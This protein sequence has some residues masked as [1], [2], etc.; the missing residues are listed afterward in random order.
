MTALGLPTGATYTDNLNGTATFNWTPTFSQS[1]VYNVTFIASDGTLADSEV[2]AITVNNVNQPPVLATIGP[3]TA[4]EGALLAFATSATDP[5]GAIPSLTAVGLPTGAAYVDSLNGRGRFTWTPGFTQAGVYNVTFIASDGTLAD[6]EVVAI[7]VVGVNMPPV[8]ATI[9][10]KSV[11]AGANLNFNTSATD[12]NATIPA[13]TAVNLP[14]GATYTNN[15]NGTGTFNWTPTFAQ[16]GLYNVTFIASDGALADSEVVAIT[17]VFVNQPPVLAAIGAKSV[18]EAVNLNFVASASDPNGTN[19]AMTAVGLPTGATYTD[20]ANGTATFNWTPTLSQAGLYN[21]TFIASD[22]TLADS[23]VVVITVTDVN[24]PPVLTAIGPKTT[25]EGTVLSFATSATDPD[26]TIPA[27]TAVGLPTGAAYVDSL[28]G[29]GRFTWTPNYT[30]AGVYNVTFIA[31]D[32][33]LADSEIVAITVTDAGN[34]PPVLAAIGPHSGFEGAVMT[35]NTSATDPD[36]TIP[37]LTA[38]NLPLNATYFDSANG[39]GTFTFTP[40]YAQAGVYNVTFIASDGTLADSELVVITISNADRAPILAAIGPQSVNAGSNLTFNVTATDPDSTIPVLT[41]INLPLHASFGDHGNGTGIF[42][43]VPDMLQ[44]GIYN[45]TFIASDGILADSEVVPITVIN[46]SN[47]PPVLDSIGPKSVYEGGQL[48]FRIH[49]TDDGGIPSL[50]VSAVTMKNFYTF[51]DSGNGSGSFT[52]V[53]DY[54]SAGIDT[55][56]FYAT[57]AQGASSFE[58]VQITTFDVNQPPTIVHIQDYTVL[59]GDSLNIRVVATDSTDPNGPHLSLIAPVKPTGSVFTDSTGGRASLRWKPTVADTG[60]HTFIVLCFDNGIP[61]MSDADTAVITVLRTNQPPVLAYIGPKS[62]N[63]GDTLRIH[64]SATDPDGTIPFFQ[65]QNMP[66]NS[67]MVDSANGHALFTFTPTFSQSGLYSVKFI[68]SDGNKTDYE[69][70]MI[71]V[72][73]IP[74]PPVLT[75]PADTQIVREG[76]SVYF[77]ISVTDPDGTI[78]TLK[79]DSTTI[80]VHAIF[81]DSLNGGGLFRFKPDFTQ[82][83]NYNVRF[84]ATD[85]VKRDTGIVAIK[86]IEAG[87]QIPVMT[88]TPT[89]V[90]VKEQQKMTIKVRATD[91]DGTKPVLTTSTLP[92]NAAFIDSGTGGGAFTWTTQQQQMGTYSVTFYATDSDTSG[93]VDSF[94]VPIVVNDSI[95]LPPD[96]GYDPY[97]ICLTPGSGT[98]QQTILEGGQ[99]QFRIMATL[100]DPDG[101]HPYFRCNRFTVT[102][103]DTTLSAMPANMTL[104]D[105]RNDTANFNFQPSFSQNGQYKLLFFMKDDRDTTR[106]RNYVLTVNV[107]NQFAP[108]V[109]DP[110]G[111]LS[112]LEGGT[113]DVMVAGSDPDGGGVTL[114]ATGLPPGATFTTQAGQPAG[115]AKS[116][117]LYAPNFAA[118]GVYTTTFKVTEN[119]AQ[120]QVD[121]EVVTIT[122]INAANQKPVIVKLDSL[123]TVNVT[124]EVMQLWL[125]SSDPD[126]TTPTLSVS[127]TPYVPY[128]AVFVDSANGRGSFRFDPTDLQADSSYQLRFV[129]SDGQLADTTRIRIQ[130]VKAVRGDANNDATIDISDVVYLIGY[131]FASNPAPATLRNGDANGD[132]TIDISDC[133]YLINYIF[134]NGPVPPP[135]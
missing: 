3:K 42:V 17:V 14:T 89:S 105:N 52:Y 43:F 30:Q 126:G 61:S 110:I 54:Y 99:L 74:Q 37:A 97:T 123:K 7:T 101:T 104:V 119:T 38:I 60:A 95:L 12:P 15:L 57:D 129:A 2:V 122:V 79:V 128:N 40:T 32:G 5:D 124:N 66:V 39:R 102:G 125:R 53:P 19:P 25:A 131:I 111:A 80:P 116:R 62:V 109:L 113:L 8:L 21:V 85:G 1:G 13:M 72:V 58:R 83:G 46:T 92:F 87:N 96:I 78:D 4:N 56:T 82:S 77:R 16:A 20:H 11:N 64:L 35:F 55:A 6:S 108:P 127:G 22:G 90:T 10:P 24:Q 120:Y 114:S 98:C 68:A 65:A 34:Q 31:S 50:L 88:V 33:T 26:G 23:E 121:S 93:V 28:N 73:N 132:G 91:A 133:V 112:V 71:Q 94:A 48:A 59:P 9:G 100:P 45:V 107:T 103:T 69:N 63:E 49:A 36:G 130:V 76:D 67:V 51:V 81:V 115:T 106:Y 84:F 47:M 41:A 117:F 18:A 29:R 134:N 118:A 75:V 44:S 86:V 27:L 70:V 135:Q